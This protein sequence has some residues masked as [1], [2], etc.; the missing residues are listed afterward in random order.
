MRHGSNGA[1]DLSSRDVGA[2]DEEFPVNLWLTAIGDVNDGEFR[3]AVASPRVVFVVP[4]HGVRHRVVVRNGPRVHGGDDHELVAVQH[5]GH[6]RAVREGHVRCRFNGTEFRN[7]KDV[8]V[9]PLKV[10]DMVAVGL[11]KVS[12]VNAG[13]LVVGAREILALNTGWRRRAWLSRCTAVGHRA[14]IHSHFSVLSPHEI[15]V[16]ILFSNRLEKFNTVLFLNGSLE[17]RFEVIA[18][19]VSEELRARHG[20]S[21]DAGP[22]IWKHYIGHFHIRIDV[23]TAGQKQGQHKRNGCDGFVLHEPSRSTVRY[24]NHGWACARCS[25]CR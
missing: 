12:F 10:V 22:V 24:E 17:G 3:Q 6:G 4:P 23:Q 21:G 9:L 14:V 19:I 25:C 20:S 16:V 18:I 13:F 8:E 15:I 2:F 7:A 1:V 11:D 5:H